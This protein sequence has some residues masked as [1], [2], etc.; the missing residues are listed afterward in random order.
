MSDSDAPPETPRFPQPPRTITD[1]AGR[2][3]SIRRFGEDIEAL[4]SMYADFAA[5]SRAQGLPPVRERDI[6]KWLSVLAEGIGVVAWHEDRAVGHATLLDCRDGTYELTIFV[7][8]GYQLAGIGSQLI[9]TLL[10][11]GQAAGI[12]HVWLSVQR[13]NH[14]AMNLYRSV[15]FETTSGQGLEHEMELTI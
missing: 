9:R 12:E 10:G 4:L 13:S 2:E 11:A 6:R 3:I 1:K 14:V 7:H 15:G 5:D 8:Q